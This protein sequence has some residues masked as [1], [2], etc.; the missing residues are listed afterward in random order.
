MQPLGDTDIL[1]GRQ[2]LEEAFGT[3]RQASQLCVDNFDRI[4]AGINDHRM[5]LF[6]VLPFLRDDLDRIAGHL[7]QGLDRARGVL[8]GGAQVLL[9]FT[10]SIGWLSAVQAPVSDL[11]HD[12]GTPQDDNLHHWLSGAAGAAYAGKRDAQKAA[13]AQVAEHAA[14]MSRWLHD[15]GRTNVAYA[16]EMVKMLVDVAGELLQVTVD[17]LSVINIQFSLDHLADVIA[18]LITE[19]VKQLVGL[20]DRFVATLGE[21]RELLAQVNG[22]AA[23]ENGRWPQAVY[24][25]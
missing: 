12:V 13:A 14:F 23:F 21:A 18:K 2:A 15:I 11:A 8:D 4:V 6:P 17:G 25:L 9:L 20:A 10:T 22:Q 16:T 24:Q 19:G 3:L 1:S 7:R 5:L